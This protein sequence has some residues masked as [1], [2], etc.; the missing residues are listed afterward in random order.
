MKGPVE[1]ARIA[2][3]RNRSAG[4]WARYTPALEFLSAVAPEQAQ[5]YWLVTYLHHACDR[6]T[7]AEAPWDGLALLGLHVVVHGQTPA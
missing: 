3:A 7:A 5:R 2:A 6:T 4:V 1:S